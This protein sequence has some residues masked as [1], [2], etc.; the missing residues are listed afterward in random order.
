MKQALGYN[1][2]SACMCYLG[3]VIG[4]IIG[5]MTSGAEWIFAVAGG[6]FLY[7]SL[8]DMVSCLSGAQEED[9][10]ELRTKYMYFCKPRTVTLP[11]LGPP[12]TF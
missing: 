10:S 3:L 1:F 9:K 4:I 11:Q 8:V 7:I 2:L 6:M 12:C 5:D